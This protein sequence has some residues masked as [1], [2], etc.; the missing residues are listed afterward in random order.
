[1]LR[2]HTNH[3]PG[4]CDTTTMIELPK[5]KHRGEVYGEESA[6]CSSPCLITNGGIVPLN[7]CF[8]CGHQN[9]DCVIPP[10]TAKQIPRLGCSHL[11][12]I[13]DHRKGDL[14]GCRA[15]QPVFEC[16]LHRECTPN[17]VMRKVTACSTCEDYKPPEFR[18]N[19]IMHVMPVRGRGGWQQNAEIVRRH[20]GLFDGKRIVAIATQSRG[21]RYPLDKPKLVREAFGEGFEFLEIPNDKHLR[22]VASFVPLMER[23]ESQDPLDVTFCCHAKGCT[24]KIDDGATPHRWRDAMYEVC[25]H[26]ETIRNALSKF[27]ICG[28]FRRRSRLG[29]SSWHFSGTFYWFRNRDVFARGWRNIDQSWFGTESWPGKMFSYRESKCLFGDG[30]GILYEMDEMNRVEGMLGEWRATNCAT[31]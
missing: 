19:L 9:V 3:N 2:H 24:K 8:T 22:E 20:R 5:C 1:M 6:Q 21:T 12:P 15:P 17:R 4:Q 23:V 31:Q 27:P 10:K 7:S 26:W 11:G 16:G 13:I 29:S 30:V 18:K 25:L 28:P 14:C